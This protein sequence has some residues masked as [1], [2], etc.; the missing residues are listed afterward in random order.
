[1]KNKGLIISAIITVIAIIAAI[2][3]VKNNA[4]TKSE[5]VT[6]QRFIKNLQ[7]NV[8]KVGTVVFKQQG[9][10]LKVKFIDGTWALPGKYNYPVEVQKIR[11]V[12]ANAEKLQ[13]IEKK[14]DDKTRLS[15]LGLG[16]PDDPKATGPRIVFM[17]AAEDKV[18]ADFV[19]GNEKTSGKIAGQN[20]LYVRNSG[21]DQAWS[22]TGNFPIKLDAD[23]LLNKKVYAIDAKRIKKATFKPIKGK[24]FE[25]TKADAAADFKITTPPKSAKDGNLLN[26]MGGILSTGLVLADVAPRAMKPFDEKAIDNFTFE[27]FDG[28]TITIQMMTFDDGKWI[29]IAADSSE[30]AKKTEA[31]SIN[32]VA[33]DW[34]YKVSDTTINLL[35]KDLDSLVAEE[36]KK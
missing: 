6:S 30:E 36:N 25:L 22:V 19:R 33:K 7:G 8:D 2:M 1:M 9:H 23:A 31:D 14:T 20:E 5:D 16:D 17:D 11:D 26:S 24:E 10:Q 15:G 27:T 3:L 34:V 29:I 21:E 32:S 35:T 18:Y 13:V 12:V 4:P 28:L